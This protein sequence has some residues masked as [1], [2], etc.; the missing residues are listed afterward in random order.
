MMMRASG[1]PLH[2]STTILASLFISGCEFRTFSPTLLQ[3]RENASSGVKH[4]TLILLWTSISLHTCS[5]RV[6]STAL[7][8]VWSFK[9]G[10]PTSKRLS[11]SHISSSN[12]AK[13]LAFNNLNIS[14][15]FSFLLRLFH[16]SSPVGNLFRITSW[17]FSI[18]M[19]FD[20][21]THI[22]TSKSF[23]LPKNSLLIFCKRVVFPTPPIPYNPILLT[24]S[25]SPSQTSSLSPQS[26]PSA[27]HPPEQK[28]TSQPQH[29]NALYPLIQSQHWSF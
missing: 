5:N 9:S 11:H 6:V 12:I 28:A 15:A 4:S 26:S 13:F 19:G 23:L 8:L 16:L 17:I 24:C 29:Q 1:N 3:N 18:L 10:I 20:T 22:T 25:S 14:A 27:S 7:D 2:S 21:T